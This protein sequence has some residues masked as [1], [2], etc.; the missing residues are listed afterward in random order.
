MV[1]NFNVTAIIQ[2]R[3]GSTRFPNKVFAQICG[4]PI[5]WHIVNRLKYCKNVDK[6]VLAT[7]NN[8][9]DD[10][11]EIWGENNNI[12]VYRGDET[13]VLNRYYN[14]A[15]TSKADIILRITADDPFRDP[16]IIDNIINLLKYKQIDFA[17]NNYP[18]TFPEGLDVEVFT[19][20]ALEMAERNSYDQ[21]EREHVTQYFYRHPEIFKQENFSYIYNFSYLR[22]TIDTEK[23]FEMAKI[24]YDELY[25]E[26]EIFYLNDILKLFKEKPW[27]AEIN[28]SV[29]RSAMYTDIKLKDTNEKIY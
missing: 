15:L 1:K 23:D 20:T 26:G 24:I 5:I 19:F 16:I 6:I 22:L 2:A 4:R 21:F 17:Y 3:T 11:L 29:A 14:A 27:I 13:D 12:T 7:T 9:A 28:N 18:P 10:S 8:I 25:T